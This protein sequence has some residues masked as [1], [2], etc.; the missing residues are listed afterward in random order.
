MHT[1]NFITVTLI[2]TGLALTPVMG[3]ST[4]RS[5]IGYS[6]VYHP[7][8]VSSIA[9]ILHNRGLEEDAAELIASELVSEEEN[10]LLAMMMHMLEN[11]DIVTRDEV[12]AYLSQAA[13]HKQKL[14]FKSYDQL[15]GMVE[16]IRQKPTDEL[17]R[18]KLKE[19]ANV[20]KQLFA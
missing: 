4:E 3:E 19:L 17:T 5:R 18:K 8:V 9:K 10:T 2:I 20:T 6:K 7:S 12:L 14:D 16:K 13:L 15:I 1:Q 11:H